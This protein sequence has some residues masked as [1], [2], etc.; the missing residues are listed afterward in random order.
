MTDAY[1]AFLQSPS[2]TQWKK[3]G[4]ERRAGVAVPLFSIYSEDS[5][6]IGEIPDLEKL[7]DWCVQTGMSIVQ[8]LPLNDTGFKYTPYDAQSSFALD[9][10]YLKLSALR[11]VSGEKYKEDIQKIRELFPSG[12]GRVHY[13]VKKAKLD[14][15]HRMYL[16]CEESS[17]SFLDYCKQN[18]FWLPDFSVYKVLKEIHGEA[19]WE[20]WPE[21]FRLKNS[22]ALDEIRKD[23][24]SLINFQMWLQWQ[25]YLQMTAIKQS[26]AEKRVLLLGDLPFLVSK[27]SADVWSDQSFFKLELAAGAPPDLYF[28][29][30]QKWGMPPYN[31]DVIGKNNYQY[32]I[33]R[34]KYSEQFYDMY[35]VDH[36]VGIFRVWTIPIAV[37]EENAGEMGCFDPTD[38]SVWEEHGKKLL[39]VM[40]QNSEMLPC[41]EDLGTVPECSYTT[42]KEYG[43]PGMDIQRWQK[44]W[45]KT[46]NF[47]APSDY[48]ENSIAVI[49]THD[50]SSFKLWWKYEAETINELLFRRFCEE[51]GIDYNNVRELLF[52][53]EK[54]IDG[55]LMWK[56]EI[57]SVDKLLEVI[58]LS[59]E[60]ACQ[61]ISDYESSYG[62]KRK[63]L[64][65]LG[66]SDQDRALD[67]LTIGTL[68]KTG[69]SASIFSIQLLQDWLS[70]D[71][72]FKGDDN[73]FRFNVPGTF[74]ENNWSLVMPWSLEA[75]FRD[76]LTQTIK[77]INSASHRK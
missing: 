60:D 15:L 33:E 31:W 6:G 52:N 67:Q 21:P 26:A 14:L 59:K 1:Q 22:N 44:D 37:S 11:N 46:N 55:R 25:L 51:K 23:H 12:N 16:D 53:T 34:L 77:G 62:E 68:K 27:D 69:Q 49:S 54:S 17:A 74:S 35:R 19:S 70:C 61:V 57:D 43:I 66:I 40:L 47:T 50:M 3:V 56:S 76:P 9:P 13:D 30:G 36:A 29:S 75:M 28:A 18:S 2:K 10:M 71:V 38:E 20:E 32:L 65:W 4:V 45:G 8:L 72:E 39:D 7:I 64:D 42:L 63:L 41:A 24:A 48:R 5:V 73:H 58:K